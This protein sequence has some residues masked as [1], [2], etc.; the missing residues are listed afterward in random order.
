MAC[1]QVLEVILCTHLPGFPRTLA[2]AEALN[3]SCDLDVAINLNI[4]L[5]TLKERLRHRW[6]HPPSGRVYNMCFNPPRVQVT[7][8]V[9]QLTLARF[10][11]SACKKIKMTVSK[12]ILEH[13]FGN[14]VCSNIKIAKS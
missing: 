13:I 14:W 12:T 2:Q 1:I 4:P 7:I 9:F 10:S 3:S 8:L 6:I 5:E 11:Q